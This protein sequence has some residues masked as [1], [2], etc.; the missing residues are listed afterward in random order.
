M[1]AAEA[2]GAGSRPDCSLNTGSPA[3]ET[4]WVTNLIPHR[5]EW[6][7]EGGLREVCILLSPG[8]S[9]LLQALG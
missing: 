4:P 6:W 9:H 8:M 7:E 1:Q 5:L 2:K 3:L